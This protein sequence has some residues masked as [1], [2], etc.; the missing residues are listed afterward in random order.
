[1]PSLGARLLLDV[2]SREAA[3]RLVATG[4]PLPPCPICLGWDVGFGGGWLIFQP[5]GTFPS[6]VLLEGMG[7]DGKV[8][9]ALAGM[10]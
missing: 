10:L 9:V 4:I 1:M 2:T 6:W 3:A 7:G 5:G 8:L